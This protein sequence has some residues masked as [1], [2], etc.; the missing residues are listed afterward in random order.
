MKSGCHYQSLCS[1]DVVRSTASSPAISNTFCDYWTATYNV[2]TSLE[3]LAAGGVCA[4]AVC[5]VP[6]LGEGTV[7][8]GS[9]SKNGRLRT[10]TTVKSH[11][12]LHLRVWET[13]VYSITVIVLCHVG[14]Y[15]FQ[16]KKCVFCQ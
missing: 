3:F 8:G 13:C 14:T 7:G 5:Q 4:R 6:G 2:A 16:Y 15:I 10:P 1:S 11:L 9:L 12:I